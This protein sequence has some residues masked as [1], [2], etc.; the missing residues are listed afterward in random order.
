MQ[1]VVGSNPISRS[2][3]KPPLSRGFSLVARRRERA[4]SDSGQRP[5]QRAARV[6]FETHQGLEV[7][8]S[9]DLSTEL[10]KRVYELVRAGPLRWSIGYTFSRDGGRPNGKLTELVEIE[11]AEISA[12][13]VPANEGA[14]TLSVKSHRPVQLVTVQEARDCARSTTAR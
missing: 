9:L 2:Q 11:L 5:G 1:K 14:R 7:S 4:K 3:G 6:A 13:P 12:V 8:G 10:G